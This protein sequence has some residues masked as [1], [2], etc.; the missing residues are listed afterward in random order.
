MLDINA[1]RTAFAKHLL[2][3][4]ASR[5][6]LDA[7]LMHV[8]GLAYD[9][10]YNDAMSVPHVHIEPVANLH[11]GMAHGMRSQ[12]A[13]LRLYTGPTPSAPGAPTGGEARGCTSGGN[14]A[15]A[16]GQIDHFYGC[17]KHRLYSAAPLPICNHTFKATDSACTGCARR[18]DQT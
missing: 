3:H 15:T 18:E 4:A 12:M 7:A 17:N 2:E 9:I 5:Y 14:D 8:I 11:P 16:S 10:G 1:M 6:S 13:T